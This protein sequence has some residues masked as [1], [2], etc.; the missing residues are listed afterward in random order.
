MQSTK[1]LLILYSQ[2][3]GNN[4]YYSSTNFLRDVKNYIKDC[5]NQTTYCSIKVSRS[6]MTR[7][8]DFDKYNMLLNITYHQKFTWKAIR[9]KGC[10]MDMHWHLKLHACTSLTTKKEL[11]KWQLNSA[12]SYGKVFVL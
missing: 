6:G 2:A 12:C 7:H 4:K 8:F 9:V 1:K 10:G 3:K 5:K 11:K